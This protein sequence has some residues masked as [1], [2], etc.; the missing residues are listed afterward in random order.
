[1]ACHLLCGSGGTGRR[2][3]L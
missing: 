2:T 3:S 1:M